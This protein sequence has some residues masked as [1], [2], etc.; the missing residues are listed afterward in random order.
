MVV[1]IG[2]LRKVH[3][4]HL[5]PVSMQVPLDRWIVPTFRTRPFAP[6]ENPRALVHFH[7][8]ARSVFKEIQCAIRAVVAASGLLLRRCS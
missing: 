2:M 3:R 5:G 1:P 4:Q 8:P 6:Y 7:R